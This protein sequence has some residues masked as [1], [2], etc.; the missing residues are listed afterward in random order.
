[1]VSWI[2]LCHIGWEF[3]HIDIQIMLVRHR[4][5]DPSYLLMK[6]I[7][8]YICKMKNIIVQTYLYSG[9]IKLNLVNTFIG[10]VGLLTDT[11]LNFI[12]LKSCA[13]AIKS[14]LI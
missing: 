3:R 7:C 6:K 2:A 5:L 9:S 10:T 12:Q 14:E 1:M 13:E 8:R 4:H 11:L